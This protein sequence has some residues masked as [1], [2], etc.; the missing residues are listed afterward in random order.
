MKSLETDEMISPYQER[1]QQPLERRGLP[2]VHVFLGPDV[3]VYLCV[4]VVTTTRVYAKGVDR[5]RLRVHTASDR[6]T[7][8]KLRE[9]KQG[10]CQR[11]RLNNFV[12]WE[13]S[14][15]GV[16][17]D[18]GGPT[19]GW[20]AGCLVDSWEEGKPQG[21]EAPEDTFK[22]RTGENCGATARC[23]CRHTGEL[24]SAAILQ[25]S[26]MDF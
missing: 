3:L 22:A 7:G 16:R 25:N 26:M 23:P 9:N 17:Y 19:T 18:K 12:G 6:G 4:F 15:E 21:K 10:G 5:P 13:R 8:C 14:P 20:L 11:R 24:S 2:A 1:V